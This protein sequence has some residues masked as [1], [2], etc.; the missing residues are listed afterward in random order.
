[1]MGDNGTLSSVGVIESEN[2]EAA[3]DELA[4]G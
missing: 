3:V 1:M 4:G 2:G